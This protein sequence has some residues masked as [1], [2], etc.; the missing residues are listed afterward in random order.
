MYGFNYIIASVAD[1]RLLILLPH[2]GRLTDEINVNPRFL[3]QN[4]DS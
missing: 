3:Q 1:F 2:V 4:H